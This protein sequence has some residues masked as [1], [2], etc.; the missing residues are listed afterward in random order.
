LRFTPRRLPRFARKGLTGD[1]TVGFSDFGRRN[2]S[3][4][5]SA[6]LSHFGRPLSAKQSFAG[7][8][9]GEIKAGER[10]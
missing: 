8:R 6:Q 2:W 9:Q 10:R 5:P 7:S 1:Q 3:V 4:A